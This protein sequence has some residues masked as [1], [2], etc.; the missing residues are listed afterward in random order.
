VPLRDPATGKRL[1]GAAQRRRARL[2]AS[3]G[4]PTEASPQSQT[5]PPLP[6]VGA[7]LGPP[8]LGAGV[9]A[10]ETWLLRLAMTAGQAAEQG[11]D[12]AR[13]LL[14]RSL[15]REA[16][17]LRD[18]ATRS[19]K[20]VSLLLLRRGIKVDVS[21]SDPPY[22]HPAAGALWAYLRLVTL[23]YESATILL[24]AP[25]QHR[26]QEAAK[27]LASAGYVAGKGAIDALI[28]ELK[29]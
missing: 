6:P 5:P 26:L 11:Q 4:E 21:G 12:L 20:A 29:G 8:P 7:H 22:E 1:S 3:P 18:K 19:Q 25:T 13:V 9:A 17:K 2:C 16:G 27:T 15:V 24:D 10:C 14:V 28:S 23:A